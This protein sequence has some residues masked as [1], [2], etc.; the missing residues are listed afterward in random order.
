MLRFSTTHLLAERYEIH[1]A[2]LK[3]FSQEEEGGIK[4]KT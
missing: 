3:T 2:E 1:M 4:N